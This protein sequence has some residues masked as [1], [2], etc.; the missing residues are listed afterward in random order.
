[1]TVQWLAT[2][3]FADGDGDSKSLSVPF[4]SADMVDMVDAADDPVQFAQQIAVYLD[5]MT[6]GAIR[7]ISL[8]IKVP[9]P[10]VQ[11]I[12]A[13]LSDVQELGVFKFRTSNGFLKTISV[14]TFDESLIIAGTKL[15]DQLDPIIADFVEMM[16]EPINLPAGWTLNPVDER[17]ENLIALESALED[18]T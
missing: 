16:I 12:P 15:I 18:F 14:P 7:S 1:M 9:L 13:P 6:G 11:A 17:G 3:N 8:S 4:T 2:I 5:A 10:A